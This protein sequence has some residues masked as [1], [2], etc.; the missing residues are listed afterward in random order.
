MKDQTRREFIGLLSSAAVSLPD[1]KATEPP[2]KSGGRPNVILIL[3]DDQGYGDFGCY[4]NTQ[5]RTPN[6]D[7]FHDE[8]VRFSNFYVQPVCSPTRT[9]LNTGRYNYRTGLVDTYVGV[10]MMRATETTLA[11][12]LSTH[13]GYRTGIFGKWHLGDHY[14]Y[15]PMDRGFDRAVTLTGGG[16]NGTDDPP[17][18][19]YSDPVLSHNGKLQPDKG[20][21]TDIFFSEALRFIE[22]NRHQPFF[23]YIPTNIVHLP[24]EVPDELAAPYRAMGLND[25]VS[26]LYGMVT[27]LDQNIGTLLA[28]LREWGLE[29]NTVVMFLT[30]NGIAPPER[31]NVGLRG[32]KGGVYEG[33]IKTPFFVRW[34]GKIRG[35]RD[36]DR[37]GAHIDLFPTILGIC[38]VPIPPALKLDGRSLLPLITGDAGAWPDRLLFIQQSRPDTNGWNV[39]R[40]YTHCAVR[41]QRYKIV[42]SASGLNTFSR[43]ASFGETELYD[44]EHDPGEQHNIAPEHPDIVFEMRK[45]YEDWFWDVTQGLNPPVRNHL[46]TPK[47]NPIRLATQ[48]MRGPGA[49]KAPWNWDDV[50]KMAATEMNGSGY[51]E[52]EVTRGGRYEIT[53]RLGPP[54]VRDIPALK[55]GKALLSISDVTLEKPIEA[56]ASE[57]TFDLHVKAGPTRLEAL[58]TGQRADGDAVSPV[59]V[60]VRFLG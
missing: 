12:A 24:L 15:R 35:G 17:D 18:N 10:S 39:P 28:K 34:P 2:G 14:P 4:G 26:K 55:P 46:G 41:G 36:V 53:L 23:I 57:I 5:I 42:M 49:A 48:D 33:G 27:N 22:E 3:T 9:C 40:P 54:G 38:G 21:C 52:V 16:F 11:Q 47:E 56:G 31:Y 59:L 44:L 6:L 20:Y 8:S 13:A 50:H 30:D 19:R 43:P 1:I 37:I 29:E 58:L 60:D 25:A 45:H 7:H 51:Y 32:G